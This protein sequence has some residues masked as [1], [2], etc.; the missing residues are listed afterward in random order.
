TA[1][2]PTRT[3][4]GITVNP[5]T[6]ATAYVTVS[7]FGSGHVFKTTNTGGTWTDISGNLPNI[8][9]NCLL[10]DPQNANTLYVGTDI[11]VFISTTGG[12]T[13]TTFNNG[14]PP[15][16]VMRLVNS[17]NTIQAG[18][19]GR[20]AY[21]LN[22]VGGGSTVQFSAANFP[23]AENAG[24]INVTVSRGGDT[25]GASS[26]AYATSNGTAKEGKDYVA[27]VGA[28]SFAAG[29]TSKTFPVLV[30]DNA[31]VDGTRTINLTLSGATGATLAPQST[32]TVGIFGRT[33]Q[34]VAAILIHWSAALTLR[35][36]FSFRPNFNRLATW[37]SGSIKLPTA[38]ALGLQPLTVRIN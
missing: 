33:R 13:W 37:S 24:F 23:A 38:T 7:G 25:T 36:H 1:G 6:P 22:D 11:G 12:N 4:T 27:A 30:I 9:T 29:E 20:G 8:P 26:V 32:A 35:H 31:F 28:V 34:Q 2:L 21:Q 17:G 5:T 18:T 3:I 19:Y 14:L 16:V 10:I 15:V